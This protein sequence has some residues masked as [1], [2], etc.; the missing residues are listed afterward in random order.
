MEQL[1]KPKL[2]TC[3]LLDQIKDKK[4]AEKPRPGRTCAPQGNEPMFAPDTQQPVPL[5]QMLL[6]ESKP[7]NSRFL[8]KRFSAQTKEKVYLESK[9]KHRGGAENAE[10]AEPPALRLPPIQDPLEET[11]PKIQMRPEEGK[12][13]ASRQRSAATSPTPTSSAHHHLDKNFVRMLKEKQLR[14][15]MDAENAEMIALKLQCQKSHDLENMLHEK[16]MQI[17]CSEGEKWQQQVERRKKLAT[18][19]LTTFW[20]KQ[21]KVNNLINL[22]ESGQQDT[23]RHMDFGVPDSAQH[24]VYKQLADI[25]LKNAVSRAM[26]EE[27]QCM[28][29]LMGQKNAEEAKNR[30]EEKKRLTAIG[31]IRDFIQKTSHEKEMSRAANRQMEKQEM[32][33]KM[34]VFDEKNDIQRCLLKEHHKS[35]REVQNVYAKVINEDFEYKQ[36]KKRI[37]C[38]APIRDPGLRD[39]EWP[40]LTLQGNYMETLTGAHLIHKRKT[41]FCGR[42]QKLCLTTESYNLRH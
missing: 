33:H 13:E 12:R 38:H 3:S 37:L 25:K 23:F 1:A 35:A 16:K 11:I 14:A 7:H 4:K 31:E 41:P 2:I 5:I 9:P 21:N 17:K 42:R 28:E 10:P 8:R 32:S 22:Q 27:K 19:S 26:L 18:H 39:V 30:S 20:E 15:L 24:F 6:E 34:K 36:S 29:V 40:F